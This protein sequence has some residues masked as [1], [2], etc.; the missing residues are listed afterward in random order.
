[1]QGQMWKWA[2]ATLA[3]LVGAAAQAQQLTTFEFQVRLNPG[4][5]YDPSQSGTGLTVDTVRVGNQDFVFSTYYHYAGTADPTWM[6]FGAYLTPSTMADYISHGRPATI[7][8]QWTRS[9]GG[10][11]FDCAYSAPTTVTPPYGER[12]LRVVSGKHLVMPASGNA[13]DRN[14]RLAKAI[15]PQGG[16]LQAMLDKGAVW[17]VQVRYAGVFDT[18]KNYG[19]LYFRKRSND[20]KLTFGQNI[21]NQQEPG[22]L[23]VADKNSSVQ[24]ELVPAFNYDQYF[25]LPQSLQTLIGAYGL[26]PTLGEEDAVHYE[27]D[28]GTIILDPAS[29]RARHYLRCTSNVA[30]CPNWNARTNVTIAAVSDVLDAGPDLEGNERIILRTLSFSSLQPNTG[31]K[32]EF[33]LTRVPNS[34]ARSLAP[35]L[36]TGIA[37]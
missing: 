27:D 30:H 19:W 36:P 8:S 18:P 29:G 14:M 2:A 10:Q 12:E 17:A 31:W 13:P 23:K 15:P 33:Q 7:R 24:Y 11:C 6:N 5:Y 20:R 28:R 9:T 37:Q 26:P 21:L 3:A 16:D 25:A 34:L 22:W 4:V 35:H 1:M 32:Q